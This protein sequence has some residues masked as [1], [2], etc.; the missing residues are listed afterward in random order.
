VF[1]IIR[2]ID[3]PEEFAGTSGRGIGIFISLLSALLVI[4]AGLLRASEEL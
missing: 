4:V 1:V 2:L 3:V